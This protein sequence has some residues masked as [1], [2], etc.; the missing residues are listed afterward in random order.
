MTYIFF[1]AVRFG[2]GVYFAT[3][4]SYSALTKY[5]VP[6][7]GLQYIYV[8]KVLVGK[9]TKGKEGLKDPPTVEGQTS[10]YDSV[11]DN[12]SNPEMFVIFYDYESYPEYL[13][14]LKSA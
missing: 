9:Y 1:A 13:V 12:V 4:A 7:Q 3:K 6:D 10:R 2:N 8:A 5:A 11:V 14:T